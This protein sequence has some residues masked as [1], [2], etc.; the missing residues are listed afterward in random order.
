[1]SYLIKRLE[2]AT[3]PD[4]ELDARIWC[5]VSG[6]IFDYFE[7]GFLNFRRKDGGFWIRPA[8]PDTGIPAYT[9][10]IDAAL[11]LVPEG[12]RSTDVHQYNDDFWHWSLW[13][14]GKRVDGNHK[15]PAIAICIA[16]LKVRE[17]VC[18]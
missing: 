15:T 6:E 18:V 7:D 5:E 4:R 16:A 9:A 17:D 3:G 13:R 2:A 10:S 11:T 8:G 12:W 14:V 1:M